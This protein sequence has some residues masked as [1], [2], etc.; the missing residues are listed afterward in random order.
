MENIK[1]FIVGIVVRWLMKAVGGY[2]VIAGVTESQLTEAIGGVL[3]FVV[4]AAVSIY[5]HNKALNAPPPQD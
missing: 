2:L 4:G 5:Q 1:G 3:V